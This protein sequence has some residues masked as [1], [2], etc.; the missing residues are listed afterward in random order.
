MRHPVPGPLATT[1]SREGFWAQACR[2]AATTRQFPMLVFR[3]AGS[4]KDIYAAVSLISSTW[5]SASGPKLRLHVDDE[6][7]V[8][9]RWD[10]VLKTD[11]ATTHFL[12]TSKEST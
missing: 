8:V 10:Q 1:G 2:Q 7:I 4:S 11:P 9:F 12:F 5:V 3:P 6:A